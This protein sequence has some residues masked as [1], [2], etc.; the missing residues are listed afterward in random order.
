MG[1]GRRPLVLHTESSTGYGGQE[2]RILTECAWLRAHGW[3]VL[4]AG[5]PGSRL[6][7]EAAAAG[8]PTAGIAMRHALHAGALAALR[9]LM[10]QRRVGIVHTHSSVDSW[11]ATLA[12]RS[13]R[14]PVVRSRHVAIAVGR[15]AAWVYHLADR[16]VTSG[17][18][19]REILVAAGVRP[20]RVVSIPPG[21]D[22]ERF[23]PGVRGD[24]VRR[25][26]GLAGPVVGMVADLRRSK[27][28]AV[29]LEAVRDALSVLPGLR[30]LVVGDGV[31]RDRVRRLVADLGLA[32][33]VAMTGFRRDVPEVMAA[34]DL[35]VLP[36]IK[37]EATS[38]V[39]LQALAVGTPVVATTVGGSP[40]IVRDG[41]TGWLVPPADAGALAQAM[42][43]ALARPGEARRR[44]AAGQRE[45][46]ERFSLPAAMARTIAV[47]DALPLRRRSGPV[48]A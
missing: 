17:E 22:V 26:L 44:A 9:R 35:L 39:L 29:F 25:E 46:R 43:D 21:V 11:L 10:A 33:A 42:L 6:L 31:G 8:V 1:P 5:Q 3:E 12:A 37:S 30:G 47:Y 20:E 2:I 18:A 13:L 40:E 16:I 24:A 34:L 32:G 48:P 7:A 27:G 14:L 45:V 36:S 38:Q 4:V 23:H 15:R 41:E 19:V 28:H